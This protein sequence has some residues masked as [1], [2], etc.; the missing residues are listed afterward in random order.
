MSNSG[1]TA[2]AE[3]IVTGDRKHLLPLGAHQGVAIVTVREALERIEARGKRQEARLDP[4]PPQ[5]N[6]NIRAQSNQVLSQF[7]TQLHEILSDEV[8]YALNN[9][10]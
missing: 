2:R 7:F 5:I 6:Q 8:N 3:L 1:V 9:F 4:T 10:P